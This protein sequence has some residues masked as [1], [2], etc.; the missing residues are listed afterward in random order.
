M[1]KE[2]DCKG[3]INHTRVILGGVAAGFVMNLME[4]FVGGMLLGMDEQWKAGL[5][6]LGKPLK[7]DGAT[8]ASFLGIY[9]VLG[10]LAVWVYAAIRP[11]FGAGPKTALIAA[12][13]VWLI[14]AL[15]P[16][17]INLALEIYPTR[18]LMTYLAVAFLEYIVGTMLGGWIY[19]ESDS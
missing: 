6:A 17:W 18:T 3:K 9:F 11:R 2:R 1:L 5:A 19:R 4:M 16:T 12:I 7:E 15:L 10:I 14:G 8:M 13:A